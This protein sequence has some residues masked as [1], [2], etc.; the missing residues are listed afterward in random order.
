M[1]F[2]WLCLNVKIGAT[3]F[4]SSSRILLYKEAVVGEKQWLS[5]EEFYEILTVSQ[6]VPGPNLINLVIYISYKLFPRKLLA[7]P[8]LLALA[9]PG[10]LLG[11]FLYTIVDLE[12][13]HIVRVLEGF[14]IGSV[15]LTL[16]FLAGI[17][18]S[19]GLDFSRHAVTRKN[20]AKIFIVFA[21]G[22]SSLHGFSLLWILFL[23]ALF[24][25]W[26]ERAH[27]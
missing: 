2:A 18:K 26:L 15:A 25:Y 20:M 5:E 7:I 23:G 11:V 6:L 12:N 14:S 13:P 19:I 8:A 17:L 24:S 27:A 3:S 9:L 10:A 21:V 16:I 4:G 1:F 22:F